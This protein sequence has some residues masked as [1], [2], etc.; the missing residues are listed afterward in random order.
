MF[1]PAAPSAPGHAVWFI[2]S[3]HVCVAVSVKSVRRGRGSSHDTLMRKN[4]FVSNISDTSIPRPWKTAFWG[5]N[6]R[7]MSVCSGSFKPGVLLLMHWCIKK[8]QK[9]KIKLRFQFQYRFAHYIWYFPWSNASVF[10]TVAPKIKSYPKIAQEDFESPHLYSSPCSRF[11]LNTSLL[12][13]SLLASGG[14]AT[15]I[16]V[17]SFLSKLKMKMKTCLNLPLKMLANRVGTTGR[18]DI[19]RLANL[20]TAC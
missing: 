18:F 9:Y 13:C 1:R 19:S 15:L 6:N 2:D 10:S 8:V 4:Q 7:L 11:L 12:H 17:C 20:E 14:T 3:V 5:G 16:F